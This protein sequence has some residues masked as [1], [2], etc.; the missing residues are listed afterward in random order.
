[1]AWHW[2][3]GREI[4]RRRGLGEMGP[5]LTLP[6]MEIAMKRI[7]AVLGMAWVSL[8]VM[9]KQVDLLVLQ[10]A[11]VHAHIGTGVTDDAG[12]WLHLARPVQR[13]RDE[14]GEDRTLLIDCGDTCQGSFLGT[15]TYGE[16][17]LDMLRRLRYDVWI[18]GNHELDFGYERLLEMCT[19]EGV[20]TIC[21]NLEIQGQAIPGVPA[22]RLFEKRGARIAVIGATASYFEQWFTAT[23]LK[24]LRAIPAEALLARVLPTIEREKPDLV[25][26]AIHQGWLESD[27]RGVNE[28]QAIAARFPEIDLILGAHTHRVMAGRS[29]GPATW[30]V[31]PGALGTHVAVI[32]V[33]V[34]TEKHRP[35]NITSELVAAEAHPDAALQRALGPALAESLAA[36]TA[37]VCTLKHGIASKGRAGVSCQTSELMCRAL[38]AKTGASVVLHG[39]LS[40]YDLRARTVR[41]KDLFALV[42][43]EN[44]IV[45]AELSQGE[46][47]TVVAE[48]LDNR[49]SYVFCG[50]WGATFDIEETTRTGDVLPPVHVGGDHPP[51]QRFLTAFNSYTA[52]GGG[53]RFP[54]L[55]AILS[56]PE[57]R[58]RD[59]GLSSRDAVREYLA[60]HAAEETKA[61]RWIRGRL[62]SFDPPPH[63]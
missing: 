34:D 4:G 38:A 20:P 61:K 50:P 58:C 18:P 47:E 30:Y 28:V 23:A 21:G 63:R 16:I 43:Y 25:V 6:M 45:L 31:Q 55:K 7:L 17:A 40:G 5:R 39:R 62:S 36:S 29:I 51:D 54:Q 41:E 52:A 3:S 13:L 37:V 46:L 27:P 24:D 48:Q 11:D 1:M 8:Q 35:I 9:G 44:S 53:G 10:T 59:T 12:D 22:W 60:A 42:P 19:A 26:L 49:K 15:F 57:S 32:R 2:R 14:H 56:K 33:T